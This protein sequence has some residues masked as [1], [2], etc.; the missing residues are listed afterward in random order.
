MKRA[1]SAG[2]LLSVVLIGIYLDLR[3]TVLEARPFDI[4]D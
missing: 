4:F 1:R 2:K 3:E